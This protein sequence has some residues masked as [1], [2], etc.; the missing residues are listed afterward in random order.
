[1][2]KTIF[3][4]PPIKNE[5]GYAQATQNRQ[6][7]Y[8]KD[9]T[10]IYPIIPA[11]FASMVMSQP[12]QEFLWLDGVAEKITQK[13]FAKVIAEMQ[14]DFIVFEANTMVIKQYI[15]IINTLKES[16][17][18]IKIILTGEHYT[19]MPEE[20]EKLCK[21]D[22]YIK[23]GK[24]YTE[25][26]KIVT[27]QDW[28][29][30]LPIINRDASRWWLYAYDNGNFREEPATY[31]MT[32]QD[33][34]YRPKQA[35]TFCTWVHYHPENK[36]RSVDDF[37]KEV[38]HLINFGFKEFF[39]D[40]GTFPVGKWLKEFCDKMIALGYNDHIVWG[41]NM[42]F[43]ALQAGEL[44]LMRKAGCRFILWGF[45]S[46]NQNTL[47][48]LSKG[49]TIDKMRLDLGRASKVG[50]WNHLTVMY[51]YPW[52]ELEQEKETCEEVR[53]LMLEDKAQSA[54]ATI[55]MPYPG[56]KAFEQCQEQGLIITEDWTKW[57]MANPVIKLK[58]SFDEIVKLQKRT[59]D[60]AM[61]PRFIFNKLKRIRTTSDLKYYSRLSK[62]VVDRFGKILSNAEVQ[63]GK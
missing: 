32:A 22:Y 24:W 34:W 33:C 53:R 18:N 54:Q 30:E 37:L 39:D 1:M 31:T 17:P 43:G 56:T 42:R 58:Y 27:N 45:E 3:A 19:A 26:F 25:A 4:V 63:I 36:I 23:G 40:S 13:E 28:V 2:A 52:E 21:A 14:P 7:Q 61:H 59:Y 57:D 41:C 29:G 20:V 49:Y 15:G 48:K 51:G 44:A 35:C 50:I 9:N 46:S 47:D 12:N 11:Y 8:F 16:F 6:C 10:F 38:E 60:V 62:K 55:F 5:V